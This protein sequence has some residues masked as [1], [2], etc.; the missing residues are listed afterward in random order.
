MINDTSVDLKLKL[1]YGNY[2]VTF[3]SPYIRKI[4]DKDYKNGYIKRYFV[5]KRNVL[6]Y[7][8]ISLKDY[9]SVNGSFFNKGELMWKITGPRFNVYKGTILETT[10]VEEYN[11][12]QIATLEQT[13]PG[14][15]KILP[16]LTQ[17]WRKY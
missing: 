5:T 15:A 6:D 12:Y 16:D 7:I 1:G 13:L 3:P 2:Q 10:G 4:D 14:V 11:A 17:Y 8:E 9:N